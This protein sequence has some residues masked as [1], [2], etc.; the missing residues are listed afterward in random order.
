MRGAAPSFARPAA[1]RPAAGPA[2][3]VRI[4][5]S[6]TTAM[7]GSSIPVV[8]YVTSTTSHSISPLDLCPQ[9]WFWLAVGLE[10]PGIP[11]RPGFILPGCRDSLQLPPGTSRFATAISANFDACSGTKAGATPTHPWCGTPALPPGRYTTS[12]VVDIDPAQTQSR[13]R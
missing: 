6:R 5:L 13:R 12:V 1:P 9:P 2:L 3:V 4:Q 11:F 10:R 7:T 8:V